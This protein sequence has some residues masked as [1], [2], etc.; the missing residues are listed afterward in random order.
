MALFFLK[1]DFRGLK[2]HFKFFFALVCLFEFFWRLSFRKWLVDFCYSKENFSVCIFDNIF[3]HLSFWN[4]IWCLSL[5]KWFC[6]ACLSFRFENDFWQLSIWKCFLALV[7]LKIL[8]RWSIRELFFLTLVAVEIFFWFLLYWKYFWLLS[9]WK[10]FFGFSRFEDFLE[11][12]LLKIAFWWMSLWI[13]YVRVFQND[14]LVL[15]SL[16]SFWRLFL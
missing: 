9:L 2:Y 11:H 6:G 5:W 13:F 15:V 10:W 7:P 8:Y 16:K 3:W 4:L 12:L 1:M 14:F